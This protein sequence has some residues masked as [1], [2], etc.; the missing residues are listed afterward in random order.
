MTGTEGN[1]FDRSMAEPL[2][3]KKTLNLPKT[4]F[5]M[6]ASLPQNEPKQLDAWQDSW[7]EEGMRIFYI[8][9]RA[10]IDSV[11]PL[12]VTPA[13]ATTA[14]VFV[15]RVEVL[16]PWG[17]Q[18]LQ[19]ALSTGSIDTLAKFGRFLYPFLTQLHATGAVVPS[20]A[21]E[22]YLQRAYMKVAKEFNSASC[23]R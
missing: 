2:E 6:K 15:G 1:R 7:F 12:E 10:M 9:P 16:S 18:S 13:P 8:V 14:R 21:T 23:V 4:D 17:Q 11:L 19:R 5:L 20:R 3:L 22:Q